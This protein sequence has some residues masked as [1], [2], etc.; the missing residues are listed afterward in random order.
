MEEEV[1][2]RTLLYI[3]GFELPDKNAAAHRVIGIGKALRDIGFNVVFLGTSKSQLSD[4]KIMDTKTEYFGFECFSYAYPNGTK[5]WI[6]QI[7]GIS[8]FTSFIEQLGNITDICL[9]NFPAIA[10]ERMV[11]Y[12][13]KHGIKCYGDITEWYIAD[14]SDFLRSKIKTFDSEYRMRFVNKKLDGLIVI[15]RYLQKY[16]AN[17]RIIYIP[18]LIDIDDNKWRNDYKKSDDVLRLVYAG[19]PGN[20]DKIDILISALKHVKR[21]YILDIFGIT[22]KEYLKKRHEDS[23]FIL[24]AKNI[25]FHGRQPH[26]DILRYLKKANYSCFFRERDKVSSAGFPTK[27]VEAISCGTP[28]ITNRTSNF[29]D[30]VSKNTNAFVVNDLDITSISKALE[31]VPYSINVLCDTFDYRKYITEIRK[32]FI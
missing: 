24:C 17:R 8:I 3:G 5:E 19:D 15:S 2:N 4:V 22:R 30:Y 21:E 28:V 23:S 6:R 16:Y 10:Q 29:S 26:L 20:K 27:F 11:N 31:K 7:S 32:L 13:H 18:P 12:C 1:K 25:R 14:K 9:Y